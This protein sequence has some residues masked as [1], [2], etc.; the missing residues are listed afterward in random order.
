MSVLVSSEGAP[1]ARLSKAVVRAMA[2]RMLQALRLPS[3]ELS[4]VLTDDPTIRALNRDHREKDR[5]T[6][7]LAFSQNEDASGRFVPFARGVP[8]VLGDV[9]VS[10]DTAA[11]QAREHR[12]T[13]DREV[14]LLLAHGVLHL[15]GCDHRDDHEERRMKARTQLLAHVGLGRRIA[16]T[17]PMRSRIRGTDRPQIAAP[18]RRVTQKTR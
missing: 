6:D 16:P 3:A 9:V 2:A 4:V 7:V 8:V 11:R 17:K 18:A 12:V 13:L 14:A 5:P 10:L 15:L 1:A